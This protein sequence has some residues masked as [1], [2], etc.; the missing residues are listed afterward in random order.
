MTVTCVLDAYNMS[1]KGDMLY[2]EK[3]LAKSSFRALEKS[4]ANESTSQKVIN[5]K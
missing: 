4:S 1:A 2:S 3:S 5:C